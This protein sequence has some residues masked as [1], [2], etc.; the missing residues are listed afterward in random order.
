M[1]VLDEF[2]NKKMCILGGDRHADSHGKVKMVSW[3]CFS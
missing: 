3:R 2:A 1:R